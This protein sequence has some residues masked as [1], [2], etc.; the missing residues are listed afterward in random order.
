M[1]NSLHLHFVIWL[2]FLSIFSFSQNLEATF[3]GNFS[4]ASILKNGDSYYHLN[5]I[6][7]QLLQIDYKNAEIKPWDLSLYQNQIF[8]TMII[9]G[10]VVF[11][12][13]N[14][15]R[16]IQCDEHG[17]VLKTLSI[18][19]Y[20]NFK[21]I[22]EINETVYFIARNNSGYQ[23]I[24]RSNTSFT[25][26]DSILSLANISDYTIDDHTIY[27]TSIDGIYK[28]SLTN[29]LDEKQ[30][31][32]PENFENPNIIYGVKNNK[33][34]FLLSKRNNNFY[35][36]LYTLDMNN[37]NFRELINHTKYNME[38][39]FD[40]A[41][42]YFYKS[43]KYPETYFEFPFA[44]KG[45][46]DN[47]QIDFILEP[48]YPDNYFI[49]LKENF[50]LVHR[51]NTG[52]EIAT[53][54]EGSLTVNEL[55]IGPG[56][57]IGSHLKNIATYKDE[58][59]SILT[60]GNDQYQYL[61]KILE[62][63]KYQCIQRFPGSEN[64][65]GLHI[66]D[67]KLFYIDF[68]SDVNPKNYQLWSLDIEEKEIQPS[69]EEKN[70]GWY[71]QIYFANGIV[72]F[73]TSFIPRKTKILNNKEV[74]VLI[75]KGFEQDRNI[76]DNKNYDSDQK[77]GKFILIKYDSAGNRKWVS[78]LGNYDSDCQID[79]EIDKDNNL[80]L[81]GRFTFDFPIN[82]EVFHN[83]NFSNL[84]KTFI[85]KLDGI[86]GEMLWKRQLFQSS[87]S[88][89][90]NPQRLLITELND[91]SIIGTYT[92]ENLKIQNMSVIKENF[93]ENV[94]MNFDKK[95]DIKWLKNFN[96]SIHDRHMN[97]Y[98]FQQ[99]AHSENYM[100]AQ[101][102]DWFH[103]WTKCKK[104]SSDVLIHQFDL[105]GNA[106]KSHI[107]KSDD[108]LSVTAGTFNEKGDFLGYGFL[109]G[110]LNTPNFHYETP[111]SN[112]C[113]IYNGF[114]FMI[115]KTSNSII[116]LTVSK[117]R[118]IN[119]F[120]AKYHNGHIYAVARIYNAPGNNDGKEYRILKFDNQGNFIGSKIICKN[121]RIE[122]NN[123]VSFDINNE[124]I[125]VAI[126]EPTN[127]ASRK[128]FNQLFTPERAPYLGLIYTTDSDWDT[129]TQFFTEIK[130][131]LSA[132]YGEFKIYPNPTFDR[133]T[134]ALP[135]NNEPY[136]R[137]EIY[138]L[139]GSVLHQGHLNSQLIQ[140]LNLSHLQP[141]IYFIRCF[142][143]SK[144]ITAK[145]IKM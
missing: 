12:N 74:V 109:R 139:K 116:K 132:I 1:K 108:R 142:S 78:N 14:R 54:E 32:L 123:N 44:V 2:L 87:L 84:N 138:D 62:D 13:K 144:Q 118:R 19:G 49:H 17:N 137:Y 35:G 20:S 15:N 7:T 27:V 119:I 69:I 29:P 77:A 100:V 121:T 9:K 127:Y 111:I 110:E 40:S 93:R 90:F 41:F 18:N 36:S 16:I 42:F 80:V 75:E 46:L 81:L 145:V 39:I 43:N 63:G 30:F 117:E 68:E 26:V 72:E 53:L 130:P 86:S 95:G 114:T 101:N 59:Y 48:K 6:G 131:D 57:S 128:I 4:S 37:G 94:I 104:S 115:D 143:E 135:E 107:L 126:Q 28:K 3:E 136:Q 82:N 134:I 24:F 21:N 102:T 71:R 92:V 52:L 70:T 67:D 45:N 112:D 140:N 5:H 89:R 64:Y 38:M 65:F 129:E 33:M 31:S 11:I 51:E 103:N 50:F 56:G 85:I 34:F 113:N 98:L 58:N 91:I 79:F 22:K 99:D 105:S 141:G 10:N 120:D 60:N 61:Y 76:Y 47:D 25:E 122:V 124:V 8:E 73:N 55:N 96:T 88:D 23:F 97:N 66:M 83:I 106:I 125:A 133:I